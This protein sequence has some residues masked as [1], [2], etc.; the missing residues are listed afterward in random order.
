MSFSLWHRGGLLLPITK[1]AAEAELK[2]IRDKL[3]AQDDYLAQ[4]TEGALVYLKQL[5][6]EEDDAAK[7]R[8]SPSAFLLGSLVSCYYTSRDLRSRESSQYRRRAM[9]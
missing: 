7:L 8:T 1:G 9:R 4:L 6:R 3:K 2:S 5:E